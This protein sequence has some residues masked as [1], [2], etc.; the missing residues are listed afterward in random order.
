MTGV[1]TCALPIFQAEDA[2]VR[3][4][5]EF[6]CTVTPGEIVVDEKSRSTP[7]L[8]PGVVKPSDG[9]EWGISTASLQDDGE[10][11][12][13][14]REV[15]G[16]EE[17]LV[18]GERRVEV[19]H[20]VLREDVRVSRRERIKRLRRNGIEQRIDGVGEIGRAHV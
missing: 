17:A 15:A 7:T 18:P 20:Q 6:V 16:C 4:E 13:R 10:S 14:L 9:G 11:G 12:Q 19:V 2:D 5:P 3:A 8:K 1:Q